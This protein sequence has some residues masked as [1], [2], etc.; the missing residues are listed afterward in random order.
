[1]ATVGLT[2]IPKSGSGGIENVTSQTIT[3]G[4]SGAE[5][6]LGSRQAFM[7]TAFATTAPTGASNINLK[8]GASG[9]SA[10]AATDM[11]LPISGPTFSVAPVVFET[12]DEFQSIRIFNNTSATVVIY[13]ML[14][15]RAG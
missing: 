3:T 4:A 5:I 6:P 12:G 11:G 9:L 14:L 15:N 10:A 8:F 1:M 13:V 2:C 7:L